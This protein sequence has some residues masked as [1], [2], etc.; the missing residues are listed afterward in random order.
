MKMKNLVIIGLIFMM[1]GF[2]FNLQFLRSYMY[3]LASVNFYGD[4]LPFYFSIGDCLLFVGYGI[5][6]WIFGIKFGE[7]IGKLSMKLKRYF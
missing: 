3:D 6:V 2:W 1:L 7:G 4:I 5:F